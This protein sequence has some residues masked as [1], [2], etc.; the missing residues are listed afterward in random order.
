MVLK[1][2]HD[3]DTLVFNDVSSAWGSFLPVKCLTRLTDSLRMCVCVHACNMYACQPTGYLV[4][5]RSLQINCQA[6]GFRCVWNALRKKKKHIKCPLRRLPVSWGIITHTLTHTYTRSLPPPW[7]CH[8]PFTFKSLLLSSPMATRLE[9]ICGVE[10]DLCLEVTSGP[11]MQNTLKRCFVTRLSGLSWSKDGAVLSQPQQPQPGFG[12]ALPA[13]HVDFVV[14]FC[15]QTCGQSNKVHLQHVFF[16][17]G[18]ALNRGLNL[19][20]VL[21]RWSMIRSLVSNWY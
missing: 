6:A 7:W 16:L 1:A 18:K 11:W 13:W 20:F 9:K 21:P 17:K 3:H 10:G 8:G 2:I 15:S 5:G 19:L 4:A 14:Y 12:H